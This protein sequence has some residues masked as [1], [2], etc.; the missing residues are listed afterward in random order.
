MDSGENLFGSMQ[1]T[2]GYLAPELLNP[3][4]F[5]HT[6]GLT[7]GFKK[8]RMV[9]ELKNYEWIGS[10]YYDIQFHNMENILQPGFGFG[11]IK[12]IILDEPQD[13]KFGAVGFFFLLTNILILIIAR[14]NITMVYLDY[15]Y[16][17]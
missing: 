12:M 6:A 17:Q 13:S 11:F 5:I 16:C 7:I 10:R 4:D 3:M 15:F 14:G 2:L 8:I 1:V 9:N